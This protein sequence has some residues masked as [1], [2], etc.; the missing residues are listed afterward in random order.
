MF[1]ALTLLSW[2]LVDYRWRPIVMPILGGASILKGIID[3]T[4]AFSFILTFA[5]FSFACFLL[6]YPKEF[7]AKVLIYIGFLQ[8]IIGNLQ[9][10]N[11]HLIFE[12]E[13]EWARHVASG[14]TGHPT[15]FAIFMC[16]CLA[17]ALWNRQYLIAGTMA[18]SIV[19]ANSSMGFA[20]LGVVIWFFIW[21]VAKL[22]IAL[23]TL[24]TA[25]LTTAGLYFFYPEWGI[26][27]ITGRQVVWGFGVKAVENAPYFGSGYGSWIQQYLPRYVDAILDQYKSHIPFQ[28]H[29]DYL[30]VLVEFGVF[31][32]GLLAFPLVQF[33]LKLRPTW[34]HAVCAAVL[35]N[36]LANFPFQIVPIALIFIVSFVYSME[37]IEDGFSKQGNI[38]RTRP[39]G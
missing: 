24:L 36:A 25:A 37:G 35:V 31:G 2:V 26:W 17:P 21:H 11:I 3:I 7:I 38:Q 15:V 30:E 34:H 16:C 22:R 32:V 19:N 33:L 14:L 28:L 39:Q 20:S 29:S 9:A 27:G 5:I 6:T 1:P 23:A 12:P 4:G 13:E 18:L 10:Y 8:A